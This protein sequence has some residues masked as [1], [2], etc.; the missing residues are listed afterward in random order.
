MA[1]FATPWNE[2]LEDSSP[3]MMQYTLRLNDL[4]R[5]HNGKTYD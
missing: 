2:D 4:K 5:N 3:A 1:V